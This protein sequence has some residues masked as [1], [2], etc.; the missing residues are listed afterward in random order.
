MATETE[1]FGH[2]SS[3]LMDPIHEGIPLYAHERA[4][5]DHQLFQRLR[6]IVQNDITSFVFPGATHTRFQHSIGAMHIAGRLFKSIVQQHISER[7]LTP[8]FSVDETNR[9]S[10]N[11]LFYCLRLAA[12]ML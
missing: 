2:P 11:Y 12:L 10:I 6:W 1:M 3:I 5:I 9:K 8:S 4:C 7:S